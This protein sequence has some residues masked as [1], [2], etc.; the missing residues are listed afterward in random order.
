MNNSFDLKRPISYPNDLL[1]KLKALMVMSKQVLSVQEKRLLVNE[2]K[3]T[4]KI[5]KPE[6]FVNDEFFG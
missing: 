1:E 6:L 3:E 5:L 2:L 4:L